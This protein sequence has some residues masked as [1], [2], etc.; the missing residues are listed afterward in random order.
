MDLECGEKLAGWTK[1]AGLEIVDERTS[2]SK[3]SRNWAAM[4][5]PGTQDIRILLTEVIYP[6]LSPALEDVVQED[7][8]CRGH[9]KS[10]SRDHE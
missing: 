2:A 3:H 4:D 8:Y 7:A 10:S 9:S 1:D 6:A 5:P